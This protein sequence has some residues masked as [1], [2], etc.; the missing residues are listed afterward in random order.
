M[1]DKSASGSSV[2]DHEI[3]SI[4]LLDND[5]ELVAT[6]SQLLEERNFVVTT[7]DNGVDGLKEVVD[8][9]FDVIICDLMMPKMPGDMFYLAVQ[10]IKPH[11]C[12]RFIFVTGYGGNPRVDKFL[13]EADGVCLE[14]PI[15]VDDLVSAIGYI[16]NQK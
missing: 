2:T 5:I 16:I 15:A 13:E 11:L 1:I 14:K 12:R 10:R 3:R 4:L 7:V 6:L 9:D 8:M